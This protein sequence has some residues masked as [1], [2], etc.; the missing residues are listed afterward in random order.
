MDN[1]AHDPR[2]WRRLRARCPPARCDTALHDLCG[3][4]ARGRR[5]RHDQ[6]VLDHRSDLLAERASTRSAAAVVGR[7]AGRIADQRGA[8]LAS[9]LRRSPF[10][11]DVARRDCGVR[12]RLSGCRHASVD[13]ADE[14]RGGGRAV[15]PDAR[16]HRRIRTD[17]PAVRRAVQSR[18]PQL[19]AVALEVRGESGGHRTDGPVVGRAV[20]DRR[21]RAA[22]LS[23]G[24]RLPW[25]GAVGADGSMAGAR[26]IRCGPRNRSGSRHAHRLRPSRAGRECRGGFF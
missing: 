17:H 7:R 20:R 10:R 13:G 5:R 4:L 26:G 24:V 25:I 22:V 2:S 11:A 23:G 1:H 6:R 12:L 14:Q 18:R 21:R 15:L 16:H 9:R 8:P 19:H 3:A